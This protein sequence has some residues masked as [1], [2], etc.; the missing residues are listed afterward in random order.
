MEEVCTGLTL[1]LIDLLHR[2]CIPLLL[3][4]LPGQMRLLQLLGQ[5]KKGGME[6]GESTQLNILAVPGRQV[7][8]QKLN[9]VLKNN[10]HAGKNTKHKCTV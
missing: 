5:D 1:K 2:V 7:F 6:W 8:F 9:F 3:E 10:A 4:V